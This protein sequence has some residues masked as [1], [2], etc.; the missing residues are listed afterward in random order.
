TVQEIMSSL[1]T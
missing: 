1:T